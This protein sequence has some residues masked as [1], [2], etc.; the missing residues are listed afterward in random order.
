MSAQ[1]DELRP[2]SG[3]DRFGSLGHPSKFQRFRVLASLLQR[4]R[5]PEANQT[6]HDV[7]P[8]PGLAH[9]IY[10]F[11]RSCPWRNFAR[12]KIHFTSKSYVLLYWQRYCTALQQRASAKL[13]GVVHGMELRNFRRGRLQYAAGRPS[14]WA[15]AHI[16]V[17]MIYCH[18]QATFHRAAGHC[19]ARLPR[20]GCHC[21]RATTRHLLY[22]LRESSINCLK[23][24]VRWNLINTFYVIS[25]SWYSRIMGKIITRKIAR[26]IIVGMGCW[27]ETYA[28]YIIK[29]NTAS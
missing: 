13:C 9:Y 12:C 16:L 11:G 5:S 8:S 15:S 21:C 27:K 7:W 14:C 26:L 18:V 10:I 20:V 25:W 19:L 28:R 29:R 6:L 22:G 17:Y 1:Y 4:R 2:T 24:Q 3:W 23:I